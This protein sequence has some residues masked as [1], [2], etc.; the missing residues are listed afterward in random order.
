[1]DSLLHKELPPRDADKDSKSKFYKIY[2]WES[3]AAVWTS[4]L[5][6]GRRQGLVCTGCSLIQP[7]GG[8][9]TSSCSS[10][11]SK[12]FVQRKC[13]ISGRLSLFSR[14]SWLSKKTVAMITGG[15]RCC[16]SLR[17]PVESA[18]S[19]ADEVD[20]SSA[21]ISPVPQVWRSVLRERQK[22]TDVIIRCFTFFTE[23]RG[24]KWNSSYITTDFYHITAR[25]MFPRHC[26]H[27]QQAK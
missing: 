19:L 3:A 25:T 20:E 12:F 7:T 5:T 26:G 4:R 13:L 18:E 8:T 6:E 16:S 17:E 11:H 22:Q 23:S 24:L 21:S 14:Q 2:R 27:E 10:H 15:S 9:D 1:M